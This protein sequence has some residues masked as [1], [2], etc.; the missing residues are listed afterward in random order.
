MK[1]RSTK[2]PI[3]TYKVVEG[4][5]ISKKVCKN[6]Q[7][8]SKET[9]IDVM[10]ERVTKK[11]VLNTAFQVENLLKKK[12]K[13]SNPTLKS[14]AKASHASIQDIQETSITNDSQPRNKNS[15]LKRPHPGNDL[16]ET[17]I[18]KKAI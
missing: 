7:R 15:T 4:I 2:K 17:I 3:Y 10:A 6:E 1:F 9:P 13:D 16:G 8:V 14:W 18:S 11:Q 5:A 12:M